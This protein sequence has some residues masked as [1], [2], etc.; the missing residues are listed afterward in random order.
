MFPNVFV[1]ERKC[2]K[3]TQTLAHSWWFADERRRFA[4][5]AD[6]RQTN[7]GTTDH[8]RDDTVRSRPRLTTERT[9]SKEGRATECASCLAVGKRIGTLCVHSLP[10]REIETTCTTSNVDCKIPPRPPWVSS[11]F[12]TAHEQVAPALPHVLRVGLKAVL[13]F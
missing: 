13:L 1:Q 10:I 3:S 2:R 8:E 12:S 9:F 4:R 5:T 6:R 11:A 7:L